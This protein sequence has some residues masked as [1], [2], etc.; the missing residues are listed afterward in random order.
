MT[1]DS[2]IVEHILNGES[3][4]LGQTASRADTTPATLSGTTSLEKDGKWVKDCFQG[5]DNATGA[6]FS[7]IYMANLAPDT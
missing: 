3:H 6:N 1:A 2:V 7:G 4:L 5:V